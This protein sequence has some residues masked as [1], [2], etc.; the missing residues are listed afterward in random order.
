MS[1]DSALWCIFKV[2]DLTLAVAAATVVEVSRST[3]VTPIPLASGHVSGLVNVR[4]Q[5]AHVVDL[6]SRLGVRSRS[7]PRFAEGAR[8]QLPEQ[9]GRGFR[10]VV[11][12][13]SL[14]VALVVDEVCDVR[15]VAMST[16]LSPPAQMPELVAEVTVCAARTDAELVLLLDVDSVVGAQ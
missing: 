4:G 1:Q 16:V 14:L 3:S 5:V 6:A 10:V 8:A 7:L 11:R 13:G 15:A 9:E 2:G 12:T